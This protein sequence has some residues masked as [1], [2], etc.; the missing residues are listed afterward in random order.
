M[1]EA[2]LNAALGM[3]RETVVKA[4]KNLVRYYGDIESNQKS[5][6]NAYAK[7]LVTLLDLETEQFLYDR[8]YAFDS[9]IGFRGEEMGVRKDSPMTW[10]VDP[11]DGTTH[12]IRGLPFC[13]TMVALVRN[14]QVILSVI[15]DFVHNDTY[16]A[17]KGQGAYKNEIQISVSTR[18][19]SE[20]LFCFETNLRVNDNMNTY[21]KLRKES[22]ILNTLSG[23]FE[24]AMVASGK[25][26]GRIAKD[27]FG[28]DYDY[29]PGSLLVAEAGGIVRNIGKTNYDYRNHD[30][31]AANPVAYQQL[32][33]GPGSVFPTVD[34]EL[35]GEFQS[36][37]G[38]EQG[39]HPQSC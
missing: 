11:I 16:W 10:L 39:V 15:H 37:T 22:S 3:V 7:N 20:C 4:G 38:R 14:H 17:I 18:P 26:D 2:A 25:R 19:L 36:P 33:T 1:D 6:T 12:F 24:F 21:L 9:T 13:T 29:A 28:D 34:I 8:F 5:S 23:G 27:P 35:D 30:Y 31:I 32:T